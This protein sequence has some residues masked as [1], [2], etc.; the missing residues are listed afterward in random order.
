MNNWKVTFMPNPANMIGNNTRK[1]IV[2][3]ITLTLYKNHTHK[4]TA[5]EN[6]GKHTQKQKQRKRNRSYN[7]TDPGRHNLE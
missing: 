7:T 5:T 4:N 1:S 6:H 2:T 3:K